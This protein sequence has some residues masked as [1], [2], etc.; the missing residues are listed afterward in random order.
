MAYDLKKLKGKIRNRYA[1]AALSKELVAK[2]KITDNHVK[3]INRD[4]NVLN[5]LGIVLDKDGSVWG[6]GNNSYG[7]C[8]VNNVVR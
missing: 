5:K 7:Q 3:L 8:L 4:L 6:I 1:S 2:D